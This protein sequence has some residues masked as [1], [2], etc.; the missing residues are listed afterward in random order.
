MA[1]LT[2][3]FL[4]FPNETARAHVLR[5]VHAFPAMAGAKQ[6]AEHDNAFIV[7]D[8]RKFLSQLTGLNVKV[9]EV[10]PLTTAAP[11]PTQEDK[12]AKDPV[13]LV[14]LEIPKTW[15]DLTEA[16]WLRGLAGNQYEYI[17]YD[18]CKRSVFMLF[19]SAVIYISNDDADDLRRVNVHHANIDDRAYAYIRR[20]DMT[21]QPEPTVAEDFR[22][23]MNVLDAAA[24]A[25]ERKMADAK[26]QLTEEQER[27][28]LVHAE[29]TPP[30]I[31]PTEDTR[32]SNQEADS[33]GD[34][35]ADN[36]HESE[37]DIVAEIDD[38]GDFAD[39]SDDSDDSDSSDSSDDS[40]PDTQDDDAPA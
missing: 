22:A 16:K 7:S 33:Q 36:A 8:Q 17:S 20:F 31:A 29:E 24:D 2:R 14:R 5:Q 4:E 10:E 19:P 21:S 39:D 11:V 9:T 13:G 35:Q 12:R 27:A 23:A 28:V 32:E 26:P 15:L 40:E 37:D 3:M 30:E 1:Q 34:T 6:D 18:A 25:F 38:G